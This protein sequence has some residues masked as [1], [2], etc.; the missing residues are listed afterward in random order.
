MKPKI[1]VPKS[2]IINHNNT[3]TPIVME[4]SESRKAFNLF[5]CLYCLMHQYK[6]QSGNILMPVIYYSFVSGSLKFSFKKYFNGL[7]TDEDKLISV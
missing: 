7:L 1:N 6:T 5:I 3:A 2:I 4:S